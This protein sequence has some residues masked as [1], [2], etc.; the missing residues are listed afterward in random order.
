MLIIQGHLHSWNMLYMELTQDPQPWYPGTTTRGSFYDRQNFYFNIGNTVT[1]SPTDVCHNGLPVSRKRRP[2]VMDVLRFG[3]RCCGRL[4]AYRRTAAARL[5][6]ASLYNIISANLYN[7]YSTLK[8]SFEVW[9]V[10][11]SANHNISRNDLVR[12]CRP[13][14]K[15][16][17]NVR[18]DETL[19]P[20]HAIWFIIIVIF[21]RS[22]LT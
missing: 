3:G 17:V 4:S 10:Y 13:N 7:K 5:R 15:V 12:T 19:Q 21:I 2:W 9:R 11:Y 6:S 8:P 1:L 14:G 22:S 20:C 16:A 18:L